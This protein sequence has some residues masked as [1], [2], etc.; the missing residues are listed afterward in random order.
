V[1]RWGIQN[2]GSV[3]GHRFDRNAETSDR[4]NLEG[5]LD[6]QQATKSYEVWMR[7]CT[8]VV[9]SDLRDKHAQ[10]KDDLFLFFRGTYYRWVQRWAEVCPELGGAPKV[11]AVGDLHVGSF[12]T[13]R[14]A[15][16]RLC[17]GVDDFDEAYPLPYTNDLV[18][19]A[20]STKLAI[21]AGVLKLK[22]KQACNAI[23][24]GYK[25]SLE[26]RGCPIVL[27]EE[28]TNLE[29]LGVQAFQ[30]APDFWRKLNSRPTVHNGTLPRTARHALRISLPDRNLE[31][32]VVRR[33][34]GLGSL[35]QLR[36][37][38]IGKLHGGFIAREAKAVVPSASV[39]LEGKIAHGQ[40]YYERTMRSSIRSC[41]PYQ[42]VIGTWILRRLSPD[43]NP[44]E[45][46][47]LP[48]K[49]DEETLLKAMGSEAANVHLGSERRGTKILNDLRRRKTNWLRSTARDMAKAIEQDWEQYQ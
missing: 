23:L 41:D 31:F 5:R 28:E 33:E 24:D 47:E 30:S 18:R 4:R 34:A 37:V 40:S 16:G 6:I 35:G 21:E 1:G 26:H 17:W 49:R 32:K 36:F 39:W 14:D 13:W 25:E 43:S 2:D 38:A 48:K 44:I 3:K 9:E 12:G 11:L 27:A 46:D 7:S 8:S 22:F 20:A 19:L 10:M 42:R 29:K 45:I 15:E